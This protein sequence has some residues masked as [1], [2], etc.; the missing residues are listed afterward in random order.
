M[1]SLFTLFLLLAVVV[2]VVN[3]A[4]ILLIGVVEEKKR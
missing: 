4:F 2:P 1:I 3:V